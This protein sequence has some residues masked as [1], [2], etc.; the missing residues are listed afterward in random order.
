MNIPLTSAGNKTAIPDHTLCPLRLI[1]FAEAEEEAAVQ[2][3]RSIAK[4]FA[5]TSAE[6]REAARNRAVDNLKSSPFGFGSL[7][8]SSWA[9]TA[10]GLQFIAYL[11]LRINDPKMT[12]GQAAELLEANQDAAADVLWGY[13]GL[14]KVV[15]KKLDP[16][17]EVNISIGPPSSPASPTP[18]PAATDS[19]TNKPSV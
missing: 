3:L 9:L 12:R 4:G 5:D 18:P 10:R 13:L 16:S 7:G 17:P 11:S 19:P 1:D 15:K 6:E 8:F 14:R 2:Y